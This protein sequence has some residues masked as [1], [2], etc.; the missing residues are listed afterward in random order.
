MI[1]RLDN[2]IEIAR[3]GFEWLCLSQCT[4]SAIKIFRSLSWVSESMNP[5]AFI[6]AVEFRFLISPCPGTTELLLRQ[7][8]IV[9][10]GTATEINSN[11][12]GI[13]KIT[14]TDNCST[15]VTSKD[16]RFG[17][18]TRHELGSNNLRFEHLIVLK[19]VSKKVNSG[20][21][22]VGYSYC[23]FYIVIVSNHLFDF[24][25]NCERYNIAYPKQS[26]E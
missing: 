25:Q 16:A 18:V 17:K 13:L 19:V 12:F 5:E 21:T 26:T 8:S 3:N 14:M 1:E 2:Q 22:G 4:L 24:P 9:C 20:E 10:Q 15:E 7:I 11:K 23:V 6:H